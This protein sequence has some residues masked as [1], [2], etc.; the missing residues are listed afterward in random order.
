[1]LRTYAAPPWVV[2]SVFPKLGFVQKGELPGHLEGVCSLEVVLP[3]EMNEAACLISM[4][5]KICPPKPQGPIYPRNGN[6]AYLIRYPKAPCAAYMLSMVFEDFRPESPGANVLA[7]E[8]PC[9]EH[10]L[11]HLGCCSISSKLGFCLKG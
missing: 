7:R 5:F 10:M 6:H 8:R 2:G 9:L 3:G 1:M 11:S 4:V